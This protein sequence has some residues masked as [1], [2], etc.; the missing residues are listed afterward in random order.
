LPP[1]WQ[2]LKKKASRKKGL[3]KGKSQ[4]IRRTFSRPERKK[5]KPQKKKM[6]TRGPTRVRYQR[7]IVE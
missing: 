5:K 7:G 3:S 6:R 2:G 4:L 1:S